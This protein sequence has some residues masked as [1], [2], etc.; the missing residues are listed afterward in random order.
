MTSRLS[1]VGNRFKSK[2]QI[3]GG[4]AFF[5][6][7]LVLPIVARGYLMPHRYLRVM[8][9]SPVAPGNTIDTPEGRFIVAE[10]G[11]SVYNLPICHHFKLFA[12]DVSVDWNPAQLSTDSI[13]GLQ[14]VSF[15]GSPVTTAHLCLLEA[16]SKTDVIMIP[17]KIKLALCDKP[18]KIGDKVGNYMV[19][20][21][22]ATLGITILELKLI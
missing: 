17:Q 13:T 7:L 14:D 22:D 4:P 5:G 11:D 10:H 20:N 16:P 15:G 1:T 3:I 12:V 6:Q 9:G 19:T 2:F 21:S 8:M 18:V